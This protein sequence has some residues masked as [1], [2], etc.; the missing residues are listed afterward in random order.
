MSTLSAA[1][2][3]H[4]LDGIVEARKGNMIF[5]RLNL[6]LFEKGWGARKL[7]DNNWKFAFYVG[8][9]GAAEF[10]FSTG[11]EPW[12]M[13]SVDGGQTFTTTYKSWGYSVIC[14]QMELRETDK[15]EAYE[16]L[17]RR[18]EAVGFTLRRKLYRRFLG[19]A[20]SGFA[21]LNSLN[22]VDSTAGALEEDAV[23]SQTNTFAGFNKSTYATYHRSQNQ[24]IDAGG[25][26]GTTLANRC[27]DAGLRIDRWQADHMGGSIKTAKPIGL[28]SEAA[29]K[30]LVTSQ[31]ARDM[32]VSRPS[33]NLDETSR[34]STA[35][36]AMKLVWGGVEYVIDHNLPVQNS[37][38]A[39]A[40]NPISGYIIDPEML[41]FVKRVA[42]NAG[43]GPREMYFTPK[44]G[45][46]SEVS[47]YDV[48]MKK[49]YIEGQVIAGTVRSGNDNRVGLSTNAIILNA[50]TY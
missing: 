38:L 5:E 32:V 4:I 35:M 14:S 18:D 26:A 13:V 21:S 20:A 37:G 34:L 2:L 6:S 46:L 19:H 33:G 8:D 11:L 49:Y 43:T 48:Y 30:N 39:T 17:K 44:P 23:G 22:G 36:Q 29:F 28:L 41:G 1:Q 40:T 50:E 9:G 7:P 24:V 47:G 16:L 15:M 10:E 12:P 42:K 31:S 25:T 45:P 27:L 3:G